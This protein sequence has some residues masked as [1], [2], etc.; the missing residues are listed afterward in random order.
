MAKLDHIEK[1]RTLCG[2]VSCGG[3]QSNAMLAIA[4]L[5]KRRKTPFIYYTHPIPNWLKENPVGNYKIAKETGARFVEISR[6][7]GLHREILSRVGRDFDESFTYIPRGG[8]T[9]DASAGLR[10]IAFSIA[11]FHRKKCPDGAGV[12]LASGTGTT[13]LFLQHWLPDNIDVFCVPCVGTT[14]HLNEQFDSIVV[15]ASETEKSIF[16]SRFPFVLDRDKSS[17][18]DFPFGQPN[19]RLVETY[20]E[21][22][23]TADLELDLLYGAPTWQMA[24]ADG[25]SSGAKKSGGVWRRRRQNWRGEEEEKGEVR[26][27]PSDL[28]YVHCGGLEGNPTQL[29]RYMRL[30]LL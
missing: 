22:L 29:N 20:L 26:S 23:E 1:K 2:V 8:A 7:L 17:V 16:P 21:G 4:K 12:L 27:F 25:N 14:K 11:E 19:K 3:Y 30:G 13:A 18:A 15:S 6:S 24:F 9:V 5:A 10:R 28:L